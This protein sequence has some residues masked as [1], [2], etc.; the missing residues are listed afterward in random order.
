MF[1]LESLVT[2]AINGT[3]GQH[4]FLDQAMI[5][6][7]ALGV[8]V[9]IALVALQWWRREDRP[10]VRHVLVAAGLS[11][12][13]GE[14]L[15]QLIL[16]VLHRPRPYIAGVTHLLIPPSADWSLPSDHSTAAMAI[17]ATFLLHRMPRAGAAFIAAALLVMFSRVYV[18]IHFAGDVLAGA[19]TGI[20]AAVVV[21]KLYRQG[22]P[23]DRLVTGIL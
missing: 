3:A 4:P 6:V 22:T 14:G 9:M 21:W 2:R 13:L 23:L 18:G 20:L 19:L 15:N 7:S 11:F 5:W 8:P 1:E 10:F 17:A 16:L 12:L